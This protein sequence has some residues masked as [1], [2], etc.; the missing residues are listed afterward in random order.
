VLPSPS[1]YVS[2]LP[3]EHDKGLLLQLFSRFGS[4]L[5]ARPLKT[6]NGNPKGIAF[7]DFALQES[8]AAAI[9]MLDS[10]AFSGRTIKVNYAA[11][12]SKRKGDELG[13]IDSKRFRSDTLTPSYPV[14]LYYDTPLGY[15]TTPVDQ[16]QWYGQGFY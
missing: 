14:Q 8:A 12:P 2:N 15:P 4:I 11:N 3:P 7:I 16:S 1:L 10:S 5:D 6:E 13:Q 9:D